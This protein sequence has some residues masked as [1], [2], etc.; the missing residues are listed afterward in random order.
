MKTKAS[1]FVF[2][3]VLSI[4][5]SQSW[6]QPKLWGTLPNAGNTESGIVYEYDLG[7]SS[8]TTVHDF[9]RYTGKYGRGQLCLADNGKLYGLID[10]GFGVTGG[11]MFEYDP[12]TNKYVVLYDFYDP[13]IGHTAGVGDGSL[14]QAANG[15]LYG[16]TQN[17]GDYGVGQLFEYDIESNT[18][19]FKVHF[20]ESTKGKTPVGV[21]TQA[22]NGK[23][24]GLTYDGGFNLLGV[25]YEYDPEFNTF[26]ALKHFNGAGIGARPYHKVLQ[27][28]DGKLYGMTIEGGNADKGVIFRYN[29]N[30]NMMEKLHDFDGAASGERPY[31]GLAQAANGML[32]GVAS[33]G[34]S[35]N[36]GVL[37]EYDI[38]NDIFM[39]KVDFSTNSGTSSRGD[40]IAPGDGFLYGVAVYGGLSSE[41]TLFKY[42]P[43]NT[44]VSVLLNFN[45]I[46]YGENP[47]GSLVIGDDGKLY[48]LTNSGGAYASSGVLYSYD[49]TNG[50]F[51]KEFDFMTSQSGAKIY[52]ALMQGSDGLVYGTANLGGSYQVGTIFRIDPSF[53]TYEVIYDFNYPNTGGTPYGGLIEGSNG[54]L[55]GAAHGGNNNSGVLYTINPNNL[56]Y[57]VLHHFDGTT[58]G[59]YPQE[60]LLE[61]NN[62]NLYGTT[63]RGGLNNDGVIF[64]YN[65]ATS[66]FTKKWDFLEASFGGEPSGI[67]VQA[68][69]GKIYGI[70][71]DGGSFSKGVLYEY[72]PLSESYAV[73]VN[74]DGPDKGE[75]PAGGL[76]EYGDNMLYGTASFGGVNG[77]GVLF[78]YDATA[79]TFTKLMNFDGATTGSFPYSGLCLASDDVMYGTTRGGGTYENGNIFAYDPQLDDF[80]VIHEFQTYLE[81]PYF[82]DLIEVEH[83]FGIDEASANTLQLTL[84]PNPVKELLTISTDQQYR[85]MFTIRI[86]NHLGQILYESSAV[87]EASSGI[88]LNV[89]DMKSGVYFIYISDD[90]GHV[91]YK[92]FVK[93]E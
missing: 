49:Y 23:L 63:W 71:N 77:I 33:A 72:D 32:Y 59:I 5:V 36:G 56:S 55:Y 89:S 37:F 3:L 76:V 7:T 42:V 83:D 29:I 80:S 64:E 4:S 58:D 30:T 62:G 1:L 35:N 47:V 6:A 91:A 52:S 43:G 79:G 28:S 74:F 13:D 73:K 12:S 15:K 50:I 81:A 88:E 90:Q 8:Y 69:N 85:A 84:Y 93:T 14:I 61:A 27:A 20:D 22:S 78:V 18:M 11:L 10:G 24:Y 53:N 40:L 86:V 39:K 87:T 45:D 75:S 34:G 60:T 66:T 31:G 68:A 44:T 19:V 38:V 16:V 51:T 65:I 2:I 17:G 70:A 57:T 26:A 46:E 82:S 21:L 9:F 25:L 67:L 41:G 48:G 54:L 92:K